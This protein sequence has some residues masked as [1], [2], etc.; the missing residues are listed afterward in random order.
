MPN[1]YAIGVANNLCARPYA[2]ALGVCNTYCMSAQPET[3][4]PQFSQGDRMRKA[5]ESNG[6]SVQEAADYFGVGR[7]TISNYIHGRTPVPLGTLRLW[8][9]WTSVPLE[10]LQTGDVPHSGG[11]RSGLDRRYA[12]GG[13]NVP[14]LIVAA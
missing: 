1:G 14:F 4:V 7:N 2:D 5:L 12:L 9:M 6:Y 8:S 13:A 3:R 10:W 11:P